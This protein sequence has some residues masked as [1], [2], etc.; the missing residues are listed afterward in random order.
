MFGFKSKKGE[1]LQ[2]TMAFAEHLKLPPQEFYATVEEA[3]RARQIPG[4]EM[5]RLEMGEGGFLTNRRLYLRMLRERLAFDLCAA[6]FGED[7]FFSCRTIEPPVSVRLWHLLALVG[8]FG[9][10]YGGLVGP[11]G[12][13]YAAIA[14]ATLVLA[15]FQVLRNTWSLG[16]ARLDTLLLNTA[17]I[18]PIYAAW[19]RPETYYRTDTRLVYLHVIP[20]LINQLIDEVTAAKGIKLVRRYQWAPVLGELYKPVPVPGPPDAG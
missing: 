6:P 19:F 5:E 8:F 7:Y 3:I 13:V 16:L 4:L 1:V 20:T 17:V 10:V 12:V 2:H 9:L 15:L 11:L 14:V 18:G